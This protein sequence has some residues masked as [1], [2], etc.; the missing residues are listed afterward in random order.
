MKYDEE[1]LDAVTGEDRFCDNE[2]VRQATKLAVITHGIN[3]WRTC[4]MG[5][6]IDDKD[7][8][9]FK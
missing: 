9:E 3:C 6:Y 5:S 4:G 1:V 7:T 2:N 8:N